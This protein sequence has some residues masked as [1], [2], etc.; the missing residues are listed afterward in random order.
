MTENADDSK[1]VVKAKRVR[2]G[3]AKMK[4]T[5]FVRRGGKIEKINRAEGDA[6]IRAGQATP[7]KRSEVR[8]AAAK[9]EERKN[10][11]AKK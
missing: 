8:K 4:A 11:K 1:L 3:Y 6:L 5:I 2:T 9:R 7:M 10:K